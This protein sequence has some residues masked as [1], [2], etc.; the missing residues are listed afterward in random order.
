MHTR[1][2]RWTRRVL[3]V[4]GCF[5]LRL[6]TRTTITGAHHLHTPGPVIYAG[7]H[8]S[9]FDPVFLITLLPEDVALVGPGDF[10]LLWPANWAVK[11]VGLIPMAR[12][13]VDRA[14]LKQMLAVLRG[15]GRL[16][17][18]PEGGTWEKSIENVKPGVAYVSQA[19]GARIVPIAFG[20]TYEV[21]G[22]VFRLRRPRIT[23]RIGAPLPSVTLSGD[24]HQ[25]QVELD[26]AARNLMRHIYAMLPPA[27]QARYDTWARQQFTG[28]LSFAPPVVAPPDVPLDALAELVSKPNL[29]SPLHR[30]ARLPL[31][32]LVD[33]SRFVP[34]RAMAIAAEAL[35]N[36]FTQGNYA[37]YLEYRLG[38]E[39]AAAIQEALAA[40]RAR[41]D[42]AADI[43]DNVRVA[44][45]PTVTEGDG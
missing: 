29:F 8:F 17:L 32:P 4:L 37:H 20:G 40:I 30:N 1:R 23:V 26:T 18:F 45:T 3:R 44:F 38:E 12:G 11:G 6:L 39:K 7:N 14:G 2:T 21:W 10:E 42:E 28:T 34:A 5:M 16:A 35:L 22:R 9:S 27:D 15:G 43:G 36:T 19:T 33:H 24:R 25:R 13:A 31:G 41:T